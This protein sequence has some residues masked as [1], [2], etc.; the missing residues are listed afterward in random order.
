LRAQGIVNTNL[1]DA[2]RY[3]HLLNPVILTMAL[4]SCGGD[5]SFSEFPG[6]IDHFNKYPPTNVKPDTSEIALLTKFKPR[7]FTAIDQPGPIDFYKEYIANGQLQFKSLISIP[8][9]PP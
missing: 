8:R 3:R 9:R 6:F 7:V 4:F 5:E 1:L 2:G